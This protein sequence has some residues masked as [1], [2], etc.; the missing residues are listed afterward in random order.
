MLY[1]SCDEPYL[2]WLG[3]MIFFQRVQMASSF[4]STIYNDM[5]ILG[6][7]DMKTLNLMARPRCGNQDLV[8]VGDMMKRKRKRRYNLFGKMHIIGLLL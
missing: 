2:F 4:T 3:R 5:H 8:S 6:Q 1:A 7:F